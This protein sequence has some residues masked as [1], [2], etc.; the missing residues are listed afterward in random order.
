MTIRTAEQLRKSLE[1]IRNDNERK[2][3][4]LESQISEY[5]RLGG[6]MALLRRQLADAQTAARRSEE[7]A[8]K[9]L[10]LAEEREL[11]AAQE[12]EKTR[13]RMA[14][15]IEARQKFRAERAWIAAG[16]D[17]KTFETHWPL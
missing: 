16:G 7:L 12:I 10:K 17:P 4:A 15:D 5:D 8:E 3:S 6:N 11:K 2:L 13:K 9:N 1:F 14:A